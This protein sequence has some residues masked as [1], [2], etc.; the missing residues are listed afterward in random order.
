MSCF[1]AAQHTA[2]LT[3]H[4]R[5]VVVANRAKVSPARFALPGPPNASNSTRP[6]LAS[7]LFANG[8]YDVDF[9]CRTDCAEG[10]VYEIGVAEAVVYE[11]GCNGAR[12]AKGQAWQSCANRRV[13]CS[14]S[15]FMWGCSH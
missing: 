10:A 5:Q 1:D 13:G 9:A 3:W 8:G 14:N 7:R 6:P 4:C 2:F 12:A 15:Y 11:I